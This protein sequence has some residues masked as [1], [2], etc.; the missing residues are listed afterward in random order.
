M[1][2]ITA[3]D[4]ISQPNTRLSLGREFTRAG[5]I[6]W[7]HPSGPLLVEFTWLGMRWSRRCHPGIDGC[8][9]PGRHTGHADP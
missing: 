3:I 1:S 5:I 2:E 4:T 6:A 8:H 9:H 7:L